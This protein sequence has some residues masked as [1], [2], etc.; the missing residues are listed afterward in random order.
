M[1]LSVTDR[2]GAT[3]ALEAPDGEVLM[4]LVRDRIDNTVGVCGGAISCGT[5]LIQ[6]TPEEAARLPEASA[7]EQEMLE[8]LDAKP[9][10]RLGCQVKMKPAL[11]G[12]SLTVAPEA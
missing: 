7:D 6:F 4:V 2:D 3:H 5:C 10:E 11:D 9:G 8:A 12:L 1:K